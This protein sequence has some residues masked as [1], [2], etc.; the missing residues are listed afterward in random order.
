MFTIGHSSLPEDEF[1]AL[2]RSHQADLVL[3]VRSSPYSRYVPHF[4]RESLRTL[5]STHALGYEWAGETLGGRPADATC[6]HGGVV[7]AGRLD[8]AKVR[9]RPW[10]QHGVHRTLEIALRQRVVLL[11]SEEDPRRCHRHHLVAQ[12]LVELGVR[13][14]HIRR[15]GE[16]EDA[17]TLEQAEARNDNQQLLLGGFAA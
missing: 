6:Y 9:Q 7:T 16:I 4:N 1:L 3:D 17:V 12:T 2:L 15:T 11:C 5:L 13:V 8:Y 14:L 10:Y